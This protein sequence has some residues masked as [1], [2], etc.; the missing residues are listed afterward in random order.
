MTKHQQQQA[1]LALLKEQLKESLQLDL[2]DFALEANALHEYVSKFV[3]INLKSSF[4][5]IYD[6][7]L[8]HI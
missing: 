6:L 2:D 5:P 1:S 8:I 4:Q 7:S 3:G